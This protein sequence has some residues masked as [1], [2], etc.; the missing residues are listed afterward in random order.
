[1][2]IGTVTMIMTT[3]ATNIVGTAGDNERR[4]L[5]RAST[6]EWKFDLSAAI[7][8][9]LAECRIGKSLASGAR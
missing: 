3:M 4:G 9:N 6:L 5:G 8:L 7:R 1:M 2:N